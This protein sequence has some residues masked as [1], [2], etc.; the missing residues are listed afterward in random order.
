[1]CLLLPKY[2]V[3]MT[4]VYLLAEISIII[5]IDMNHLLSEYIIH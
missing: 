1:M 5:V 3:T 4:Y 2:M